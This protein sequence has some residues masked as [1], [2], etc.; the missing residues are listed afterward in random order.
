MGEGASKTDLKTNLLQYNLALRAVPILGGGA[1][2]SQVE[3]FLD[4]VDVQTVARDIA[5]C[6][7]EAGW[8]GRGQTIRYGYH[9][10][11]YV[12]PL[13]TLLPEVEGEETQTTS[14]QE[15]GLETEASTQGQVQG[16]VEGFSV[17][18]LAEWT[19]RA[20]EAGMD[21]LVVALLET[22]VGSATTDGVLGG[23]AMFPKLVKDLE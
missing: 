11:E 4:F 9:A 20:K 16:L 7:T 17:I 3:S 12:I 23:L 13:R 18:P 1:Q 10:G 6:V 19:A 8:S 21:E 2:D 5:E 15:L 22:A 14:A